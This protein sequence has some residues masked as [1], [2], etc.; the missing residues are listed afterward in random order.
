MAQKAELTE[1][2]ESGR[3]GREDSTEWLPEGVKRPKRV[4]LAHVTGLIEQFGI[5]ASIS[6][7]GRSYRMRPQGDFAA[8]I[9]L[10]GD[11]FDGLPAIW[12]GLIGYLEERPKADAWNQEHH[13]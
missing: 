11:V 2:W 13:K 12:N 3:T 4:T 6:R 9:A 7:L 5:P 10:K 8:E 1:T